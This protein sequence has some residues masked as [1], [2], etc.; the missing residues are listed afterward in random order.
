[1]SNLRTA[2]IP[3]S[4]VLLTMITSGG[5]AA[6]SAT[7]NASTE[8]PLREELR[9]GSLRHLVF[10]G[11]EDH[12]NRYLSTVMIGKAGSPHPC[13]G[14]VVHPHLVLTAAHC[15]C[16]PHD[17][18][19]LLDASTCSKSATVFAYVYERNQDA[20]SPRIQSSRGTVRAH[21][22][23]RTRFG[24]GEATQENVSDLAVIFLEQ[25]LPDVVPESQLTDQE[26]VLKSELVVVGYGP[27][28]VGGDITG[29][30]FFGRNT[31][32]AIALSSIRAEDRDDVFFR[33]ERAGTH[34]AEGDSGGP[35]FRETAQGR[36][37]VGIVSQ[38]HPDGRLSQFTSIYPHLAWI[39]ARIAE[40]EKLKAN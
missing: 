10:N 32:T 23:Y 28:Q 24:A 17:G 36:R 8:A 22:S 19:K 30:R 34:A 15:L 26:A 25:P 21:E 20:Y 7:A 16:N 18:R 5:C 39:K 31:V 33:F 4:W 3:A 11:R 12:G 14:V 1:M 38:G 6:S 37:L 2:I 40:A 29:R 27:T 13:S 9:S 35:C